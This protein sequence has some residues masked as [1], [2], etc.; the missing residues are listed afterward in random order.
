MEQ[1][2]ITFIHLG[3]KL[4]QADVTWR[5]FCEELFKEGLEIMLRASNYPIL[6]FCSTGVHLTGTLVGLLRKSQKWCLNAVLE[7][8]RVFDERSNDSS[9]NGSAH[10]SLQFVEDFDMDLVSFDLSQSPEWYQLASE[11][12]VG[13]EQLF[14]VQPEPEKLL[15]YERYYWPSTKYPLVSEKCKYTKESLID[16]DDD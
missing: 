14:E 7:E 3:Y 13:E 8:Y 6:V 5:P 12:L 4:W 1:N 15:Q 11:T 16:E 9:N 2:D 10:Q